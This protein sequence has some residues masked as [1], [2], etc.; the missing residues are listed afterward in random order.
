MLDDFLP[1]L[2]VI[3]VAVN[4]IRGFL[5]NRS[6]GQGPQPQPTRRTKPK[7]SE[8]TTAAAGTDAPV[9]SGGSPFD[10][11]ERR[12]QEATRRVQDAQRRPTPPPDTA[13]SPAP[14][15]G[16]ATFEPSVVSA[17]P[18]PPSTPA[19]FLGREGVRQSPTKPARVQRVSTRKA[20]QPGQAAKVVFSAANASANDLVRGIVW[21]EVLSGPKAAPHLRRS[22]S[23][24]RSR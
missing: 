9:D 14:A 17:S 13:P 12:L 24:R 1:F 20:D 8:P 7:P 16:P 10:D 22:A 15:T 19:G 11:L 21:S 4:F 23:I 2:I 18:K 3:F 5:Q 6:R